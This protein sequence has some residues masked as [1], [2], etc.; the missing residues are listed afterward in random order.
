MCKGR[1][2]QDNGPWAGT[3]LSVSRPSTVQNREV[4]HVKHPCRAPLLYLAAVLLLLFF[5]YARW[6]LDVV[7]QH[8]MAGVFTTLAVLLSVL[9]LAVTALGFT[10]YGLRRKS[11]PSLLPLLTL[12]LALGYAQWFTFTPFF[13]GLDHTLRGEARQQAV[14]LAAR[15]A[16]VP[17]GGNRYLLPS[18]QSFADFTGEVRTRAGFLLFDSAVG[19]GKAA[20]TVYHADPAAMVDPDLF[21]YEVTD[22]IPLED[23]WWA[24]IL[25]TIR[26]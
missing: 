21:Y 1:P 2:Y 25:D 13:L 23:H 19:W 26:T 8:Y 4:R 7:R 15:E 18:A 12:L 11:W 9:V 10:V 6:N 3:V 20:V 5:H 24:V 22:V 16:L 17:I 14:E